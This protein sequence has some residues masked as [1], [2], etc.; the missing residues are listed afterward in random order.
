MLVVLR[1]SLH[2]SPPVPLFLP[3][4]QRYTNKRSHVKD[5]PQ[6]SR[7][8]KRKRKQMWQGGSTTLNRLISVGN[9]NSRRKP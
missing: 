7:R 3:R 8:D 5:P 2:C 6:K 4:K 9:T 1:P